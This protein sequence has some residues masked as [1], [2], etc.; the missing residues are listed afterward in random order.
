MLDKHQYLQ[1]PARPV[2]APRGHCGRGRPGPR[3]EQVNN[4]LLKNQYLQL[5]AQPVAAPAGH[6]GRGRPR[7]GPEQVDNSAP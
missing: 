1:L 5:P 7:P 6:S 4:S 2:A 3:P